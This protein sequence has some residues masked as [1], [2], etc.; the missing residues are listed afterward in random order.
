MELPLPFEIDIVDNVECVDYVNVDDIDDVVDVDYIYA[1]GMKCWFF[2][3][4]CMNTNV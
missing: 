4:N 2:V 1:V 3:V